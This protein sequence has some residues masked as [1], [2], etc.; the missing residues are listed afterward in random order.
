MRREIEAHHKAGRRCMVITTGMEVLV[1]P[2]LD[3]IDP[4]IGL[5]GCR[6][7]ARDGKLTGRVQGPLF[8]QDK[9]NILHAHCRAVGVRAQD[10]HAYS[11]HYSDVH[12][13]DAVGTA[14]CV[15]PRGRLRRLAG[16][17]GWRVLDAAS[18][19]A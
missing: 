2:V 18:A 1:R 13:L 12:M 19:Q 17:R 15:N 10:C 14:V 4:L 3:R 6:L 5:I 7:E 16:K 11:D 9:A 8:G